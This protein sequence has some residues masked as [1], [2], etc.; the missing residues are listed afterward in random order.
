MN[1]I[2]EKQEFKME[3]LFG[4]NILMLIRIVYTWRAKNMGN[5]I[6]RLLPEKI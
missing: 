4:M 6:L 2:V 1:L 5:N 3:Q